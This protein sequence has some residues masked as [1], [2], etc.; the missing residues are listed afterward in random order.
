MIEASSR[1]DQA[2]LKAECL[3]RD[4]YRCALSGSVDGKSRNK[5]PSA[6][7]SDIVKTQC[8]HILP[9]ALRDFDDDQAQEVRFQLR[10]EARNQS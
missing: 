9:F 3:R 10:Y 2:R 7:L 5:V 1:K 8:A 4:G 6:E